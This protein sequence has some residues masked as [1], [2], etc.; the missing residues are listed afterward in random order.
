MKADF[1]DSPAPSGAS[2]SKY[3]SAAWRAMTDWVR[4]VAPTRLPVLVQGE[5]GSGKEQVADML[6]LLGPRPAGPFVAFNCAAVTDSLLEAEL[7]GATRGA[8]TGSDRDRVGLF[9]RANGGTLFLDEVGDMSTTMQAKLLRVLETGRVLPVGGGL[10]LPLA[11]RIVAATHRDLE[12]R[13]GQGLFRPDLYFRLAVLRVDTPALRHRL[14]DLPALVA[15]LAVRLER[16]T[17]RTRLELTP[18]AWDWLRTHGWPGNVRELYATLARALLR[19]EDGRIDACHLALPQP[20][21]RSGTNEDP[22]ECGMIRAALAA[23]GGSI[24]GAASRIGWSRQK[25][26]RRMSIRLV[27]DF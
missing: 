12:E 14:E 3:P 16:D 19:S 1:E 13:I 4:R 26:Y 22:L 5:S 20:E 18:T 8:Y 25:L 6:H 10:E 24:A 15:E 2:N 11:V 21:A 17:G 23:A 27:G 7:F 9:R